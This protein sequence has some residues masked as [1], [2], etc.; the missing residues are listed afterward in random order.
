MAGR[1]GSCSVW[2]EVAGNERVGDIHK[3]ELMTRVG[4]S[5]S[6]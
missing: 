6:S 2:N 5:F 3:L 4:I 1:E